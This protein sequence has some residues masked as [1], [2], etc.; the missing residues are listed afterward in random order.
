MIK[1]VLH[2]KVHYYRNVIEDPGLFLKELEE[3]DLDPSYVPQIGPWQE[4]RSSSGINDVFGKQKECRL[5]NFKNQTVGDK[6][7]SKLCS[8]LAYKVINIEE[9]FC[10]DTGI[11]PGYLPT[12]FFI[13]K[14]DVGAYM[15]SHIDSYDDDQDPLTV[16]M[17]VYLN[18][19]Y[20]GGEINFPDFNISIKPEAGS[21]VVFESKD[22][23]HEPAETTSGNK[24][25]IPIFFY[26]R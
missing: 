23:F 6:I 7:N 14:Y 5:N 20:E 3:S 12:T 13:K 15:G 2:P 19:D 11:E 10:K 24:Y 1:E 25:L 8:M 18:D 26:K 4:W 16:S 22:T 21:V 17:V 9:S